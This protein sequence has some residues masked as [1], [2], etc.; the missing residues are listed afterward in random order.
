MAYKNRGI[1][2]LDIGDRQGAI[3]DFAKAAEIFGKQGN[4]AAQNKALEI[5]RKLQ[6]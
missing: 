3:Q 6:N 1:V 4:Q 5:L 2:R